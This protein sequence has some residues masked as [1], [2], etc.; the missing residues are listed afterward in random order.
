MVHVIDVHSK[1]EHQ[2][3]L[4]LSYQGSLFWIITIVE[5][6][7]FIILILDYKLDY[8][9]EGNKHTIS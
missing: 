8:I 1:P 7:L 4:K 3:N 9:L 5:G 6:D 2:N